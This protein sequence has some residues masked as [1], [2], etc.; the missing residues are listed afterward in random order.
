M[1]NLK[2]PTV[3]IFLIL[4][5]IFYFLVSIFALAATP[6]ELKKAIEEKAKAALE[7]NNQIQQTQKQ[8]NT[9]QTQTKSLQT[10]LKKIDYSINQLNL[11]IK[12]STI[13]IEKL[14]L[15][16][17]SLQQ[18]IDQ[19]N[20]AISTKKFALVKLI[21]ELYEKDREGLLVAFLKNK[22]L[23]DSLLEGQSIANLNNGLALEV[24]NLKILN[25]ELDG[26]FRDTSGK[27]QSIQKENQNLLAR[28]SIV[29]EQKSDRQSLLSQTKNQ[30]KLYA[31][32]ITSLAKK[33]AEISEEIEKIETELRSKIDPSMLPIPRPG[34]LALPVQGILTQEYGHTEFARYGYPGRFHNGVDY[35]A[36]TGTEV[37]SAEA[38][39]VVATGNTDAYCPRGAYGKFIVVEHGNNLTSLYGHLSGQIVKKGDAVT[40]GQVIGYVGRTGY[41]TGPHLHFT[42]YAGPTFYIGASRVCGPLPFGGDLNPLNYLESSD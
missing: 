40:R 37:V 1:K 42:V 5:S 28:K 13:N 34:V 23:A 17:E 25:S 41:A 39:T 22:S 35:G 8:L 36:P 29:Q 21:R 31:S 38:G 16:L 14:G 3:S 20:N 32:L 6:E 4:F 30:E 19:I 10:E 15:E 33:Q 18:D 12:S 11:G 27:K 7:I 24:G 26:R 2:T 9:T